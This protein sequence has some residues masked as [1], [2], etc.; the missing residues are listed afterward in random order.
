MNSDQTNEAPTSIYHG[1]IHAVAIPDSSQ[2][3][4]TK[5]VGVWVG[6]CRDSVE[7]DVANG[8]DVVV[9][10]RSDTASAKAWAVVCEVACVSLR[11]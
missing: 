11:A 9:I 1:Q 8:N 4:T 5:W 2:F 7:D 10:G 6:A 3:V